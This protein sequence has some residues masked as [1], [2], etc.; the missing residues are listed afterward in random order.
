MQEW[1]ESVVSEIISIALSYD[2]VQKY[3]NS[4]HISFKFENQ[5]L[6]YLKTD[7]HK[8]TLGCNKGYMLEDYFDFDYASKYMRHKYIENIHG[9]DQKFVHEY[10]EHAIGCAIELNEKAC[11]R[12]SLKRKKQ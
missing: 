12:A 4:K 8:I 2:G 1:M 3:Y 7:K 5:T 11:M 9:F 6:F 10:V